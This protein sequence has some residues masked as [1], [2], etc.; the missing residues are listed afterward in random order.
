[1]KALHSRYVGARPFET[2]QQLI[3]KGRQTDTEALFRLVQLESLVVLYGKSGTGKSSLLNAA[4]IPKLKA[5]T[6]LLPVRIRFNAY[7]EGE[8]FMAP[9]ETTRLSVR[10]GAAGHITFLDKLIPGEAS[11]WHDVKEHYILHG[12]EKGLLLVMDQFEELFTYPAEQIHTFQEQLSEALFKTVPQRYWD[13]LEAGYAAGKRPLEPA[14]LKLF[15][16]K[17]ALKVVL[18]IRSDRLHLLNRLDEH[19]PVILKNLY[20]LDALSPE[21]ARQAIEE[22]AAMPRMEVFD[23]EPF[24]YAPA[25]IEHIL[26][27]LTHE[28]QSV[29]EAEDET[30]PPAPQKIEA[31]QLQII[32]REVEKRVQAYQLR[33]VQVSDVGDLDAIIEQ[34]YDNQIR[35]LDPDEQLPARRL[36]EEGLV[37]EEEERRLSLFEGLIFK[38]YGIKPDTL[39]KLVDAHLLRAEPSLS[40]GYT[41]ELSHDTLVAPVLKAKNLRLDAERR[42]AELRKRADDEAKLEAARAEAAREK[43]KRR[44]ATVLAWVAAFT[45]V[46]SL[47]TAWWAWEKTQEATQAT[48]EANAALTTA[49]DEQIQRFTL[50]INASQRKI[51]TYQKAAEPELVDLEIA[52]QLGLIVRLD[53]ARIKLQLLKTAA[54][55]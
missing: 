43:Q 41:Y 54:K 53:S 30:L 17:P 26:D 51:E 24:L 31:T 44:R 33:M 25:A 27:F 37:F 6:D 47:V 3:F 20:E 35:S 48:K 29:S 13:V 46:L 38:T 39:R 12:G 28:R 4:V 22:P 50:E 16:S 8:A 9:I 7:R 45:A 10:G 40:G 21:S 49:L 2:D 5:E 15:Q 52:Q 36:I 19:L 34:Y 1:M 23:T 55:K 11:L 18:S 32:C 14:E 42:E